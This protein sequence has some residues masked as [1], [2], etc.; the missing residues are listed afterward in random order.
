[1]RQAAGGG[2]EAVIDYALG[3]KTVPQAATVRSIYRMAGDGS[4]TI[5][6]A[7]TPLKQDLPPPFRV[8]LAFEL[9][10]DLD[11]A[12]WYGRGPHESYVDRKH[13]AAIGLWRGAL[14]DQPHDYI[15]PQDTGNKVDVRWMQLSGAGR[16]LRVEGTQPL[17][18]TA[19]PFAYSQLDRRAPGTWKMTDIVTGKVGSLLVD[20]AQWGVGGDTRW[21]EFAQPLPQHRV[22]LEPVRFKVRLSPT[23]GVSQ[24]D[25]KPG[26]NP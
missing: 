16:G 13:S 22:K 10:A 26:G 24:P 23:D 9:P 2:Q 8:G 25:A 18:M 11:T 21:N 17:M 19:L 7:F 3:T 14:T 12:E 20:V 6:T 1:M 5:E 15:R 4:V